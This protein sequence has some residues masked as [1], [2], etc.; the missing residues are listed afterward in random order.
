MPDEAQRS[1]EAI[2][3]PEALAKR[4][5]RRT[6]GHESIEVVVGANLDRLRRYH[7]QRGVI[8]CTHATGEDLRQALR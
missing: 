4:R 8:A 2:E 3:S 5:Q 7:D 6:L 1:P